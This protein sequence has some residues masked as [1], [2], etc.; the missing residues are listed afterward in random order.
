LPLTLAGEPPSEETKITSASLPNVGYA[1]FNLTA[2]SFNC[3][4]FLRASSDLSEL[5]V[6]F[7]YNTFGN[8][9]SC[10]KRLLAD[11]RLKTLEVALINEPGHR[12]NR[13]GKYEFLSDVGSVPA[14]DAKLRNRDKR[15]KSKFNRYVQPLK[16]VLSEN[17]QQ[18]TSLIVNP[19]L[20]SNVSDR[21]G[22]VLISWTREEFPNS[23]VVWNPLKPSSQRRKN[24]RG[25]FIEG[26]NLSPN[27]VEP[28][29]YNMDGT[30]VSFPE[31]PAIGE[32]N[33]E[34]GQIKNWVQ[35]GTPLFQLIEQFANRCEVA[36]VWTAESNG[37]NERLTSFVDP[38]KR[39]HRISLD[40]YKT[41]FNE[42]RTIQN[43]GRV[44]P[45][46]FRY[47]EPEKAVESSCDKVYNIFE[48]GEKKGKLLKQSEFRDRGAVLILSNLLGT[49]R[50]VKLIKGTRVVDVFE[51][52]GRY[53]DGRLLFRSQR[54]PTTYP[55]N[56]YLTFSHNNQKICYK[57]PNPRA[58]LD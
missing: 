32:R 4:A 34:E 27:I 43:R 30:D 10:L 20:E 21:A 17:L 25:D 58:R 44:Y 50:D 54:S 52:S 55:L 22:R 37:I 48:D 14:W 56:T 2:P 16:R 31:R 26:H 5:H 49:V 57:L 41:I 8:D 9:F 3:S 18:H 7:L 36:F 13:L 15:L 42:I 38:R 24:T 28:C 12:N 11:E 19:G 51:N 35:S 6:A 29:I 39:N 23:R 1:A 47:T 45:S 33:Y 46:E 40:Q 53:K